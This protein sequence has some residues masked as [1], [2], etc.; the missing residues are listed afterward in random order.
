MRQSTS[1]RGVALVT[2]LFLMLALL[3]MSLSSMRAALAGAKSAR[4][5]RDRQVAHA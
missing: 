1:E 3:M 2:M 4:Y 5:E